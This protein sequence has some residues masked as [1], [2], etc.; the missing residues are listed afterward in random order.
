MSSGLRVICNIFHIRAATWQNQQNECV[1]SEDSDQ[2]GHSRSLITQI[3]LGI[4]PVWL[5]F[6]VR[7]KKAWILSYP[8]SAQRR[9]WSDWASTQ[10]D[11][12]LGAQSLC[13]FYH[14]TAHII[15]AS[16][17]NYGT[18]HIDNQ[19]RL[20]QAWA[21]SPEPSLFAHMKYRSR[22]RVWPNIRHLAPLDGCACAFEEWDNRG[23]KVP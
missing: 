1:H 9:L 21:P 13:W 19:W 15:W 10:S 12:V 3:S 7:M 5:V 16:S 8:L 14:V 18:Y 6:T 4:C 2:P 23:Q 20:R 17:W 22:W 11:P